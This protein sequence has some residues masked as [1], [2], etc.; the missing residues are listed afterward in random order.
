M[1]NIINPAWKNDLVLKAELV[2]LVK[3]RYNRKEILT[4]VGKKYQ[5][6]AW[7]L[8]SLRDRLRYFEIKYINYETPIDSV[9]EAVSKELEGPGSKL[10]Y[11]CMTQKIREVHSLKVPRD[12]VYGIMSE[13]DPDGLE[14][15]GDVGLSKKRKRQKRFVS[16]V[17]TSQS[18]M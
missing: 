5:Q 13:L 2:K 11:R 1:N 9:Y 16:P 17:N 4:L 8:P 10:G 15:R 6:Y 7:S 3:R 18:F 12:L 14:S